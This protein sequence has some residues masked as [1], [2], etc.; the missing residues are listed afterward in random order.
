MKQTNLEDEYSDNR[1]CANKFARSFPSND[2][3][4]NIQKYDDSHI[5]AEKDKEGV[6]CSQKIEDK[7]WDGGNNYQ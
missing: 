2:T 1:R 5:R 3:G 6:I 7:G 4:I